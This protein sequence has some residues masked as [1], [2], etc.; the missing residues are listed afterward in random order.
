MPLSL[1]SA[2]KDAFI[3]AQDEKGQRI[4]AQKI[5]MKDKLAHFAPPVSKKKT[6]SFFWMILSRTWKAWIKENPGH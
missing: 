2:L 4:L 6:I 1:E 3:A 5:E